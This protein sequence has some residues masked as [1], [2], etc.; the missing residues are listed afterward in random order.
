V[1]KPIFNA[2]ETSEYYQLVYIEYSVR[3]LIFAVTLLFQDLLWEKIKGYD[4]IVIKNMKRRRD[5][6]YRYQTDFYMYFHL[7]DELRIEFS[8]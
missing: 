5:R 2:K 7:K 8:V 6:T 4:Q 1:F 3:D